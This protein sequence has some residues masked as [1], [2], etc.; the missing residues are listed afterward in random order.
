MADISLQVAGIHNVLNSM[1]VSKTIDA[2][3]S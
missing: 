2:I 1:A 3:P